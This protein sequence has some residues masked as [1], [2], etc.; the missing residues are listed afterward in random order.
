MT[1]GDFKKL[2]AKVQKQIKTTDLKW[3]AQASDRNK[4]LDELRLRGER[5][6]ERSMVEHINSISYS[7]GK[8]SNSVDSIYV[9]GLVTTAKRRKR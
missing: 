5:L 1:N 8:F 7:L 2:V 3:F 9:P 4:L 6:E